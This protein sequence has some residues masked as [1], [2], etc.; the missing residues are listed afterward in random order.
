MAQKNDVGL[1][2]DGPQF[3]PEKKLDQSDQEINWKKAREVRAQQAKKIEALERELSKNETK[4]EVQKAAENKALTA[5]IELLDSPNQ[6][7]RL[8]AAKLVLVHNS[9]Y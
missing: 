5:L 7:L 4:S 8:E 6:S 2:N 9:K 1:S 3:V